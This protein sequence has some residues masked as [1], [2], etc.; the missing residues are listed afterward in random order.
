MKKIL[1][2]SDNAHFSAGAFEFARRLNEIE[3]ILLVG[4][5]LPA[6]YY[7]NSPVHE[8]GGTHPFF[9]PLIEEE[10]IEIIENS[11]CA[12]EQKCSENNIKHLVHKNLADAAIPSLKTETRFTDLLIIG[13]EMFYKNLGN[14]KPNEYLRYALHEAECPVLIVPEKFDFPQ[15]N[16][17]AYDGSE[18]SIY[19]IKQFKYLFPELC[20]QKTL[21]LYINQKPNSEFPNLPYMEEFITASF[22]DLKIHTL[23]INPRKYFATWISEKRVQYS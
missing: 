4:F 17:L 23:D 12:F 22:N 1:I 18:A 9:V 7:A 11:I 8:E 6:V 21:L 15:S 16:I 5:F 2:A 20:R 10:D 19:A 13:S 14:A 3:P